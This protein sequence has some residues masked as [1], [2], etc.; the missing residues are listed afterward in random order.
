[1]NI[2]VANE[3]NKYAEQI[4]FCTFVINKCKDGYSY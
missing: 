3:K 1:M 2:I 4:F